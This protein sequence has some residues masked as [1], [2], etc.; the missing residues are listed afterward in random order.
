MR[1]RRQ[2]EHETRR[3]QRSRENGP[4]RSV[5]PRRPRETPTRRT[6]L[7][8]LGREQPHDHPERVLQRGFARRPDRTQRHGR[9]GPHD[10]N[11]HAAAAFTRRRRP[12]IHPFDA[13]RPP[14]H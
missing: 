14:G 4:E 13:A 1:I 2:E 11:G 10:R 7:Q 9:E 6:L 8:R 5:R 12:P 3:W